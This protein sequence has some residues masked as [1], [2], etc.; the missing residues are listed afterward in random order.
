MVG[1]GKLSPASQPFDRWNHGVIDSVFPN[2]NI[3]DEGVSISRMYRALSIDYGIY[4][5]I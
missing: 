4:I 2:Q 3:P 5:K 1:V